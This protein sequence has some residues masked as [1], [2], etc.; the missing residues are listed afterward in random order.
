MTN[1]SSLRA[2]HDA[3]EAMIDQIFAD[4]A[5]YRTDKDAF[6]L[7]LKLARLA[8]ILRTH[9]ALENQMLYPP[10]IESDHREAALMA[11]IYRDEVGHLR[12]RDRASGPGRIAQR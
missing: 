1:L 6:P 8:G 7:S 5:R 11:R 9:F 4:I 10:M 3:A 12:A 2:Q